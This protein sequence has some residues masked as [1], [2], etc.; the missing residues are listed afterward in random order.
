MGQDP[1]FFPEDKCNGYNVD[2]MYARDHLP[3]DVLLRHL[4]IQQAIYSFMQYSSKHCKPS[5]CRRSSPSNKYHEL[6]SNSLSPTKLRLPLNISKGRTPHS[7]PS[8]TTRPLSP[9]NAGGTDLPF[10]SLGRGALTVQP[11]SRLWKPATGPTRMTYLARPNPVW[12]VGI[13]GGS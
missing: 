2:T 8:A 3:I 4:Y 9:V 13:R 11:G 10:L 12:C 7:Y 6:M 5:T 1:F